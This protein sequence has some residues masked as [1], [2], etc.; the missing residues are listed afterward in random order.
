MVVVYAHAFH[1]KIEYALVY[2]YNSS[3]LERQAVLG[4]EHCEAEDRRCVGAIAQCLRG[5]SFGRG[6]TVRHIWHNI[7][8]F[9]HNL[10]ILRHNIAILR[11]NITILRYHNAILRHN[12]A[13]FRHSIAILRHNITAFRYSIAMFRHRNPQ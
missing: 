2:A 10:A 8:T 4:G 6:A 12:M 13:T 5:A 7:A 9:H 11:H 3:E 1:S